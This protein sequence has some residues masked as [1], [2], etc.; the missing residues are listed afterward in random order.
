ML[1]EECWINPKYS[2]FSQY[3]CFINAEILEGKE[4]IV[5]LKEESVSFPFISADIRR[6][7]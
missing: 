3:E 2:D 7:N 5:S 4:M 6:F 1:N